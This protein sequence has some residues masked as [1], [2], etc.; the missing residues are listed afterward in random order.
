MPYANYNKIKWFIFKSC[1]PLHECGVYILSVV[2][3]HERIFN[4]LYDTI[5]HGLI[6]QFICYS[7]NPNPEPEKPI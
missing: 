2:V 5:D 7:H 6:L 3:W 1:W 4:I